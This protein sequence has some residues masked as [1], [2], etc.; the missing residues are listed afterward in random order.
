MIFICYNTG[1]LVSKDHFT[2]PRRVI[3]GSVLLKI[4]QEHAYPS[5]TRD[6]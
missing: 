2:V 4:S 6:M 3:R 5:G 1:L